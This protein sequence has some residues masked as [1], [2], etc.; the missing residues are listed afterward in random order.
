M[1]YEW[2]DFNESLQK[3]IIMNIARLAPQM[4]SQD[5]GIL[6]WSLGAL[7]A[8]VDT[9]PNY[10]IESYYSIIITN[11][12]IMKPL[13]LSQIIFGLS[14]CGLSWDVLPIGLR[15]GINVALRR[16]AALMCPQDIAN[17][18]YGR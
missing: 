13:E 17:S 18:A 12:L 1:S 7:D 15:W 8:P 9:F 5:V 14:G 11:L 4:N 10:V 16:V 6:T 2:S 3:I